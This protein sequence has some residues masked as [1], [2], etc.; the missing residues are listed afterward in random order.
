MVVKN[1]SLGQHFIYDKNLLKKI[2]NVA[3][4]ITKFNIIEI[5]GGVGTLTKSILE[6]NPISL[7]TIEKDSRFSE[8]Y[9]KLQNDYNNYNFIIGDALEFKLANIAKNPAIVIANLPYNIASRLL[10]DWLMEINHVEMLVLMFQ[11]EVADRL[12]AKPRTKDYGIISVLTQIKCEIK[13]VFTLSP[14]VFSPPPKVDSAVV[15]IIPYKIQ[16]YNYNYNNLIKLLKHG[17]AQR[18]K[19]ITTSLLQLF[20]NKNELISILENL[21]IKQTSRPEELTVQQ[22]AELSLKLI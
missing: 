20:K 2:V 8:C 4:D 14:K 19:V 11:K 22:F 15:K 3:D 21:N 16:L 5:G 18:R 6:A 9:E 7:V 13:Y 12:I 1:K 10:Y 17:F